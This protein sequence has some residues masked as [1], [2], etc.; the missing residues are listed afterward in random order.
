MPNWAYTVYK[1]VGLP[2]VNQA[3][4]L[5]SVRLVYWG[6]Y[7]EGRPIRRCRYGKKRC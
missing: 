4:S 3:S 5:R 6:H 7:S 2:P 1:C